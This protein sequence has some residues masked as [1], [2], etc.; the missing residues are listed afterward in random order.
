MNLLPIR[1][2]A[3]LGAGVM[4]AQIAAHL[5]NANVQAI[6]FDLPAKEVAKNSV[7]AKAIE[8]MLK[9]SPDPFVVKGKAAQ[10]VQ[11]NYDEHL[12]MLRDCDLIIEAISERMDWKKS[13]YEKVAPFIRG[14]A[15]FASNTSGLS[16]TELSNVFP[17]A[18]RHRFCGVHFFNPP[19]YMKLVE[20]IPTASTEASI[21]DQLEAF[22]TSTLGKGVIARKIRQT[23][24]PIASVCSRLRQRCI[25]RKHSS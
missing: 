19:R 9:L 16:I 7:V 25:T 20:L 8:G 5:V 24:W 17:E 4:G 3:V 12:E 2:V 11:A 23:S 15:I 14:D 1:K 10:I 13:L 21:L 6:L 18:L 22:L